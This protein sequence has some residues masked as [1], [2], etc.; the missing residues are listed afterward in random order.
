MGEGQAEAF[1]SRNAVEGGLL[2]RITPTK[3]VTE[4]DV[5]GW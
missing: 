1:G 2:V 4:N 5:A 3:A